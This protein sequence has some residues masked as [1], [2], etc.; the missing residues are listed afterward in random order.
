MKHVLNFLLAW[1]DHVAANPTAG[2]NS[3]RDFLQTMANVTNDEANAFFE[4]LA[5]FLNELGVLNNNNFNQLRK[6]VTD[7]DGAA[8]KVLFPLVWSALPARPA[9]E[10]IT[11]ALRRFEIDK[12]RTEI[13][14]DI[15]AV[16]V[17]RDA[18]TSA[19]PKEQRAV[20]RAL[21]V[22]LDALREERDNVNAQGGGAR[23]NGGG[24]RAGV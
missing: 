14:E 5:A 19:D 21:K 16:K 13:N 7:D 23:Q 3:S 24:R 15:D 6:F 12:A 18:F 9:S 8:A 10:T 20:K 1:V 11:R 22:G 17:F 4:D 2:A